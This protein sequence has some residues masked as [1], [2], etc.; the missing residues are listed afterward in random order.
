MRLDPSLDEQRNAVGTRHDVVDEL[1][2]WFGIEQC[3]EEL[4]DLAG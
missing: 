4:G 1:S 2:R 3:A